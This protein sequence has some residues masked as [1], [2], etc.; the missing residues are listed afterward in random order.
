[1]PKISFNAKAL[2]IASYSHDSNMGAAKFSGPDV[3]IMVFDPDVEALM[4]R[5]GFTNVKRFPAIRRRFP[6]KD[7][8]P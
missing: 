7:V 1:M 5:L 2:G 3:P 4:K 8:Q 6:A